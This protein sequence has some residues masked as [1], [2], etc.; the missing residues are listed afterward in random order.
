MIDTLFGW[1]V[2]TKLKGKFITIE[3]EES[4]VAD[5]ADTLSL[6]DAIDGA[7]LKN[8]LDTDNF[9]LFDVFSYADP[10]FV[11][12][13]VLPDNDPNK[14]FRIEAT[15][16][17]TRTPIMPPRMA[18]VDLVLDYTNESQ[19]ND[20]YVSFT[21]MRIPEDK[22]DDFTILSELIPA[23]LSDIDLQTLGIWKELQ[24]LVALQQDKPAPWVTTPTVSAKV[25]KKEFCKRR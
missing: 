12:I 24:N 15:K 13:K 19:P 22:L 7:E 9:I 8:A 4:L 14:K 17:S 18:E 16:N 20:I 11:K 2:G 23:S 5:D 21:A 6:A 25:E 10:G 3:F 1:Y